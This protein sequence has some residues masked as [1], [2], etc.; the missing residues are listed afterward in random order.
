MQNSS[1]LIFHVSI[2]QNKVQF[3]RITIGISQKGPPIAASEDRVL[4]LLLPSSFIGT[5][6]RS[7]ERRVGKECPV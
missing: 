5:E 3:S 7:E 1:F 4:G 6:G 2:S